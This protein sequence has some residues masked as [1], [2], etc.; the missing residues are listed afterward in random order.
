MKRKADIPVILAVLAILTILLPGRAVMAAQDGSGAT[1]Q[2]TLVSTSIQDGQ[3]DVSP[4]Q[5]IE[6]K[7]SKNVANISVKD[8][9]LT[10][11]TLTD[12]SGQMVPIEVIIA[13]DQ[14]ERDKRN[15]I[16]VKPVGNL[17]EA[18]QF[19]LTISDKVK[20]KSGESLDTAQKITFATVGYQESQPPA[21]T[22]SAAAGGQRSTLL[23]VAAVVVLGAGAFWVF[24]TRAS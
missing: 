16:V 20:A 6:L 13:D 4:D 21:A 10:C 11:F 18:R 8:N 2:F 9:N 7:F 24:K 19:T 14:M 3:S 22:N 15:D 17:A 12:E 5:T 23:L 1:S